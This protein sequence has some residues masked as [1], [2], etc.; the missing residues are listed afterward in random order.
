MKFTK[1][2][3]DNIENSFFYNLYNLR[4]KKALL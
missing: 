4:S 1:K 2:Y 3:N